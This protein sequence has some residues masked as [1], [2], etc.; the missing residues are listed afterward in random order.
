MNTVMGSTLAGMIC[1]PN[2]VPAPSSSRM[3][4]IT[5]RVRVKP[6][7][8]PRPSSA[9]SITPCLEANISARPRMMQFTTIRGRKMPREA[10]REG[11]YALTSICSTVTKVA[12]TVM[13]AGRRT[14]SG[15]IL[16]RAEMAMFEQIRTNVAATPMPRPLTARVVTARV[17]Q[18]PSTRR[19]EGFSFRRPFVTIFSFPFIAYASF[20]S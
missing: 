15:M 10:S 19:R 16:R 2:R 1:T 12:M 17:G 4:P 7:P 8:M 14:L 13:Y 3:E 20:T 18:V 9:E 6:M 11:R 5:S